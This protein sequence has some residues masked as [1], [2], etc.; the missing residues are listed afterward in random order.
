MSYDG[1]I[2]ELNSSVREMLQS[3]TEEQVIQSEINVSIITFGSEVKLHTDLTPAK[4]VNFID[5]TADGC[6]CMGTAFDMAFE[7]I[8]DKTRVPKNAYRPVVVLVSDGEPYDPTDAN[9]IE[10]DKQLARF[11]KEGRSSKCDRWSLAIGADADIDMMKQFLDHPEKEVCYVEDA[12]DIHKFFRFIS[13]CTIQ[14]SQ[15]KNP[16]KVADD[17]FTADI[18]TVDFD[19]L[20]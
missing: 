11:T 12:A 2:D 1:K 9:R 16:N 7:V 13:S 19:K 14:R 10:F 4:D 17:L 3:F 20:R 8:E 18:L 15:S 5:L 6:T